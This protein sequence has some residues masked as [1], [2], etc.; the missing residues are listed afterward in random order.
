MKIRV[1]GSEGTLASANAVGNAKLVRV[2]NSGASDLVLTH[3]TGSTVIGTMT[4]PSKAIEL[5]KKLPAE[6]LEG[7]AAL[8]AVNVA[9]SH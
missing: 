3:K 7:G 8:K 4:V 2:Y 9:Y 5:V 1:L 6:T